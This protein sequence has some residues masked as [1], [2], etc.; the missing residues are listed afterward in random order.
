[1]TKQPGIANARWFENHQG[2]LFLCRQSYIDRSRE[3]SV[4]EDDLRIVHARH[5]CFRDALLKWGRRGDEPGEPVSD[6]AA[7]TSHD[8]MND[9]RRSLLG[10]QL[11]KV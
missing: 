2:S 11:S 10:M 5:N 6:P 7:P 4:D 1:L 9:D 3:Y 8:P